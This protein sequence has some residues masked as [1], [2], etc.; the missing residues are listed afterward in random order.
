MATGFVGILSIELHFPE[1]A[2]L[3]G[4]RR[5]LK[6][7]KEQL[8]RRWGAS[9]AEIDHHELWQRAG[10]AVSCVAREY[11]ELAELLAAAERY[12]GAQEYELVRV[13]RR[14]LSFEDMPI[15]GVLGFEGIGRNADLDELRDSDTQA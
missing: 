10:L 13:E 2:S 14:I 8:R 12:L 4:K 5:H 3:K 9:V 11:S 6:S 15:A 7:A 1:A